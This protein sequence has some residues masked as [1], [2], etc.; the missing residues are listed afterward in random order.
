MEMAWFYNSR[1]WLTKRT[2]QNLFE[3]KK[4]K[5]EY[6]KCNSKVEMSVTSAALYVMLKLAAH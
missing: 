2:Q 3:K 1:L 4:Q 5:W 6:D